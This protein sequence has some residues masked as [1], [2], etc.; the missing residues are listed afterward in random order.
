[1]NGLIAGLRG[2][3]PARLQAPLAARPSRHRSRE[4]A[5]ELEIALTGSHPAGRRTCRRS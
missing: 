2:A 3:A 1:M 4:Q 5:G